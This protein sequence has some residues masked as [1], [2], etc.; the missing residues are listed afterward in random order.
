MEA[1]GRSLEINVNHPNVRKK[2]SEKRKKK[3]KETQLT[4]SNS[5]LQGNKNSVKCSFE[6]KLS[7]RMDEVLSPSSPPCSPSEE[8]SPPEEVVYLPHTS[9]TNVKKR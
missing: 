7:R 1:E 8:A 2:G 3:K 9:L 5:P 6:M 4:L